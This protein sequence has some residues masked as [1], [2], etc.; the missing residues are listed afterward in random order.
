MSKEKIRNVLA[1]IAAFLLLAAPLLA[2]TE[3]GPVTIGA[4]LQTSFAHIAPKKSDTTDQLLLNSVR[5]YVNG[6][7]AENIKFM[8]NTEY[9]GGTNKV[10][11]L[12]AVGR[13]E[14]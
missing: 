14:L 5:L 9:D 6:T 2:Q 3:L 8:F 7:A 10:G 11:I 13:I 1:F 4:G 12:D